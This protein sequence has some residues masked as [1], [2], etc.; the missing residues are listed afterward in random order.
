MLYGLGQRMVDGSFVAPETLWR[1]SPRGVDLLALVEFNPNHLLSRWAADRLASAP[2]AFA[3]YTAAFSLVTLLVIAVAAW[4]AGYRPRTGWVLLTA[5]FAALALGPFVY[6]AGVNTYVPGPWALLRYVPVLGIA[7]TPTRFAVVA[8]LGAAI[9][10]AGALA[11][12][13]RRYPRHRRAIVATV[14]LVLLFELAP[15]PRTLYSADIPSI[16]DVIADDPRP[17]RVMELPFGVRDGASSHGNFNARVLYYQTRHGKRL[18][19]GYLSRI[20]V[21]RVHEIRSQPTLNSLLKL[22]EGQ[23]LDP[24]AVE[25]FHERAPGFIT[26]ARVGYVVIHRDI[27]PPDLVALVTD[28]WGLHEIASDGRTALFVPTVG[29]SERPPRRPAR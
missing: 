10:F 19:G 3:E 15:A 17:V 4:R 8:A 9:L 12:I 20:S 11:A 26:R 14:G 21:K 22:S 5:G 16:Y 27:A 13:G 18:V 29:D 7:R 6:L 25:Q 2:T 1:S 28:A 24:A 23:T